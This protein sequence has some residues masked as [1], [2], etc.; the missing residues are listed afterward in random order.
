MQILWD[1]GL[2]RTFGS[3]II[4]YVTIANSSQSVTF[5][6]WTGQAQ[7]I[8][9]ICLCLS[10]S[11]SAS[12]YFSPSCLYLPPSKMSLLFPAFVFCSF[13]FVS[14][15]LALTHLFCQPVSLSGNL[16]IFPVS[17]C[18]YLGVSLSPCLSFLPFPLSLPD[19]LFLFLPFWGHGECISVGKFK[20]HPDTHSTRHRVP[21]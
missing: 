18:L 3:L 9:C 12:L 4:H 11:V 20:I 21:I 6:S 14:L 10:L 13:L 7:K 19:S 17:L 5:L 16:Y 1:H 8:A 2:C 15:S